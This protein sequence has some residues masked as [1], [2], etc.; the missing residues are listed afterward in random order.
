MKTFIA[1]TNFYLRYLLKDNAT[2]AALCEKQL[3]QARD[4]VI[5]I[6]F[7]DPVI[8]EMEFV[9]RSFYKVPRITIVEKLLVLV[10]TK[11]LTIEHRA[12]WIEVFELYQTNTI[13]LLD[14]YLFL[15]AQEFSSEVLS[16]DHDFEKLRKT[17]STHFD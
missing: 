12:L 15:R 3:T 2:Q 11:Y 14:C 7:T 1:D 13:A 10:K 6:V 5:E 8:L 16:F 9:L 4:G 17:A